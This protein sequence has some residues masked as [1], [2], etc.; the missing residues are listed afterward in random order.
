M[1]SKYG[2]SRHAASAKRLSAASGAATGAACSPW[3]RCSVE[4]QRS[5]NCFVSAVCAAKRPLRVGHVVF[6]HPADRAHH[7]A[8]IVGERGLDLAGLARPQIS[9]QHLA[10]LLDRLR[11]VVG[12]RLH[13]GGRIWVA[14]GAATARRERPAGR[15]AVG[16]S[17]G[18]GRRY[19][20]MGSG[21]VASRFRAE[22]A[23]S[24]RGGGDCSSSTGRRRDSRFRRG[25]SRPW[26]RQARF[27]AERLLREAL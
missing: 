27:A 8:D 22:P 3:R 9:G 11:D 16:G 24:R 20:R 4:A 7:L 23:A 15:V 14:R 6:G 17:G 5:T 26:P 13:V 2:L 25:A 19:G 10:A 1:K 21:A 18:D 12:E